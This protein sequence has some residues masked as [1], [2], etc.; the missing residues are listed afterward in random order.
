[1]MRAA[2]THGTSVS[3][4]VPDPNPAHPEFEEIAR[5]YDLA[6]AALTANVQELRR[7][8]VQEWE[9]ARVANGA[10]RLDPNSELRL[11]YYRG[12]PSFSAT[13][14]DRKGAVAFY[15]SFG[16]RQ[17][18][19]PLV[20]TLEAESETAI[21]AWCREQLDTLEQLPDQYFGAGG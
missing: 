19:D 14:A 17:D 21:I 18:Q 9:A 20:V 1:M 5:R 10:Q 15:H 4:Y 3:V 2:Q 11:K 6:P 13:L 12:V 16:N 7:R 8:I